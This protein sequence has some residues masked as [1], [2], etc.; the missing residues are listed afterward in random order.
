M[1]TLPVPQFTTKCLS[2]R[3]MNNGPA[4]PTKKMPRGLEFFQK[5]AVHRGAAAANRLMQEACGIRRRPMPIAFVAHCRQTMIR[6]SRGGAI[7][8]GFDSACSQNAPAYR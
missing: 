8:R 4:D 1:A 3:G 2:I 7:A 5:T 6:S